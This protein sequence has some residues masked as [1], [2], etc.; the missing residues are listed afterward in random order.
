MDTKMN[1]AIPDELNAVLED[2]RVKNPARYFAYMQQT[3]TTQGLCPTHA[4]QYIKETLIVAALR[5]EE[6]FGP[7]AALKELAVLTGGALKAC[8][9]PGR[10][11][12]I[13][14][15]PDLIASAKEAAETGEGLEF[16]G[17]ER[18]VN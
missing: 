3:R 5:F 17:V 7:E 11:L 14:S 8:E 15:D 13:T 9:T 1:Q 6:E 4:A 18:T 10:S 2:M 16:A 12:V